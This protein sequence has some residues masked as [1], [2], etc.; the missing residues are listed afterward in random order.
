MIPEMEN[1]EMPSYARDAARWFGATLVAALATGLLAGLGANST[2]A[3]MAFLV[4]VVWF[5]AQTGIRLSL[6]IAVLCALSFDYFFLPPFRTLRIVGIQQWVAMIA[7]VVSCAVVGRVAEMARRQARRANE[8]RE[9]LERLYTLSQEM[10]LQED[11]AGLIR[12]LPR[13]IGRI[14]AL[15]G[16]VLYVRDHDQFYA[17][18]SELP[19]RRLY[20]DEL[21]AGLAAGGSFRLAAGDTL[22][23]NGHGGQRAGSHCV[24]PRHGDR[25]LGAD[26]GG[27]RGGEAAGGADRLV[28][29]RTAH[30]SDRHS[31]RRDHT[32]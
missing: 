24:D 18:T 5:A 15:D 27:T 14:F 32:A 19:M 20:C 30:T 22:T 17:S 9:D 2:T 1:L 10:M 31:S 29:P 16:V 4:L 21:D 28:D 11:A 7:F 13:M 23:H 12:D 26:G 25:G 3:G 6:Y 8:R